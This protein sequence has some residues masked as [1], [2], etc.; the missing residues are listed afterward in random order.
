MIALQHAEW[1]GGELVGAIKGLLQP[2]R[3]QDLSR[4][5]E[6]SLR[7]AGYTGDIHLLS[8]GRLGTRLALEAAQ[9]FEPARRIVLV[10]NYVCPAVTDIID[11]LKLQAAPVLVDKDLNISVSDV[12]RKLSRNVLAVI[13]VHMYGNP[14]DLSVIKPACEQLGVATIDDAAHAIGIATGGIMLGCQ[15]HMGILSFN[16]SKTLTGGSPNGGGAIIVTDEKFSRHITN[17]WNRLP[18]AGASLPD[19]LHFV[20]HSLA[21]RFRY[22]PQIYFDG[23]RQILGMRGGVAPPM[24]KTKLSAQAAAAILAQITRL[25]AIL[26]GRQAVAAMYATE[27]TSDPLLRMPQFAPAR[28]LSRVVI[29]LPSPLDPNFVKEEMR[30]RG[31][32]SRAPYP[33]WSR[34]ATIEGQQAATLQRTLLEVPG[35]LSMSRQQVRNVCNAL[36][37]VVTSKAS[38]CSN[39]STRGRHEASP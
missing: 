5:V 36:R 24:R 37:E 22:S 7:G 2:E 11:E 17:A 26:E 18:E 12:L 10:P 25:P 15:G 34:G 20:T 1:G 28:Y 19:F 23:L 16:Q 14:A 3:S 38:A 39:A 13:A 8:S 6:A 4:E 21:D 30:R 29:E 35:G 32:R 27:L 33:A 31:I 9:A